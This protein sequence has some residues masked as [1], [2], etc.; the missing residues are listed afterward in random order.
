MALFHLYLHV[1][2]SKTSS[3][4]ITFTIDDFDFTF[5]ILILKSSS[6]ANGSRLRKILSDPTLLKSF[7]EEAGQILE[8]FPILEHLSLSQS[9]PNFLSTLPYPVLI[10]HHEEDFIYFGF[11]NGNKTIKGKPSLNHFDET[12]YNGI[13]T[14]CKT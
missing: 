12:F 10:L 2:L 8:N 7:G 14:I 13:Q 4:L 6:S 9:Q 3:F 5:S 11:V 1:I